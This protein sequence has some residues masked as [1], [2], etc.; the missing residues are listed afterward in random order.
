MVFF[1]KDNGLLIW[2]CEEGDW[3]REG[4]VEWQYRCKRLKT[5]GVSFGSRESS[6]EAY[7]LV[8][9]LWEKENA[10]EDTFILQYYLSFRRNV[11][12]QKATLIKI[13]S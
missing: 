12:F 5:Y 3:L 11:G 9:G 8:I 10:K 13:I 1:F 4:K 2:I 6:S 7:Y